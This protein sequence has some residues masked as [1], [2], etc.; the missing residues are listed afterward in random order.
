MTIQ[1]R[2]PTISGPFSFHFRP[3]PD[4][5]RPLPDHFRPFRKSS[6]QF[7]QFPGLLSTN[8]R[9]SDTISHTGA[10]QQGTARPP[11]QEHRPNRPRP[12]TGGTKWGHRIKTQ[13]KVIDNS[14]THTTPTLFSDHLLYIPHQ[15]SPDYRPF[16]G[17]LQTTHHDHTRTTQGRYNGGPPG[18]QNTDNRHTAQSEPSRTTHG[19]YNMGPQGQKSQTTPTHTPTHCRSDV[20]PASFQSARKR[21]RRWRWRWRRRWRKSGTLLTPPGDGVNGTRIFIILHSINHGPWRG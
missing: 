2:S 10:A 21:R 1:D 6:D 15:F 3:F 19:R 14:N 4:H 8:S 12:L 13:E 20:I 16:H 7:R 11:K 17:L 18:H 5:F 9:S